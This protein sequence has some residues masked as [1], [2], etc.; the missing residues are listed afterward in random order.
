MGATVYRGTRFEYQE[1]EECGSAFVAP[2]P[3]G[4]TLGQMYGDDYGQFISLEEAHSGGEGTERVLR[5]LQKVDAGRFLDYGCGGGYLLREV[6]KLDWETHGIE[7]DRTATERIRDASGAMVVTSIDE[8]PADVR[9]DAVHMG[10]VIEHLTDVDTEMPRILERLRPG[11]LLI[12]QGPL[13]ANFNLFLVGL[14]LKKLVR[15]TDSTMPPYHVMLATG[16]GQ[17]RLFT[18]FGLEQIAFDIF[19][20]AH[21][22]PEKIRFADVKNIRLTSLYVLRKL[23]QTFSGAFDSS[24][25]NRYFY[26]GRKVG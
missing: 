9:F 26:V 24:A 16:R 22:A 18:R 11:G 13:E 25:G 17:K 1:C 7:F 4:E 8:L 19:E 2:M 6:A 14:R 15:D 10:D 20:A 21:P 5:E 23:S 12:A 3:D